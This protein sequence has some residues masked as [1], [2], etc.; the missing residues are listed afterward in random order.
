[1]WPSFRLLHRDAGTKQGGSPSS[2]RLTALSESPIKDPAPADDAAEAE[3]RPRRARKP[4]GWSMIVIGVLV[5]VSATLVYRRDGI[6]G[7]AG[8]SHPRSRA[9]RR[10]PAARAGRLPARRL[11]RGN[12]AA[13][14]SVALARA[15][16][17]LEGAFDRR[18]VRRDPAGRPVHRL[19]GGGRAAD[20][21]RRFRRD[22]CDGR[23]LD[24]DRL[25]PGGGL[26]TADPRHRFHAV[27]HRD[28]AADPG[29]GRRARP[30][31]LCADVSAAASRH[32][33]LRADHR[34]HAVGLGRGARLHG[35]AAR[36][37]GAGVVAARR[38]AWTSSTSCRGS[39]SA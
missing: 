17:R 35:L 2:L 23:E 38:H 27:A 39:R 37:R 33:D 26:G 3:P 36:P 18:R 31:R 20:G 25:W 16:L 13:R 29:S 19:S 4:V 22:H 5:A 12:P 11:H 21:R 14:K 32:D 9:V 30:L 15:E 6:A 34:H 24:A 10:H 1:M 28:L 7:R 8:Y